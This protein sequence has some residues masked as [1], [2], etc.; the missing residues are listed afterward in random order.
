MKTGLRCRQ[1]IVVPLV[2]GAALFPALLW[3]AQSDHAALIK[4]GASLVDQGSYQSGIAVLETVLTR[5]PDNPE[6][7]NRL[8]K[9]YDSYSQELMEQGHFSLA[10]N[11]LKKM[12][13]EISR[14]A[15]IL[16]T[17]PQEVVDRV[18]KLLDQVKK[19]EKELQKAKT[20]GAGEGGGEQEEV[21]EIKGVKVL[22]F[23][24]GLDDP[25]LLRDLSDQKM[26]K[27]GSGIALLGAASGDKV[28]LILRVSKDLTK[29]HAGNLLKE[30]APIVGGTGGGRPDMA[31]GGG[32]KPKALPEALKKIYSIL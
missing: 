23:L 26:Q 32:S 8:L 31:Q 7:L 14:L 13:G 1:T 11:Y 9:A 10:T 15:Q 6:V 2:L 30:I 4:K 12:E 22:T 20:R 25:K 3:G 24:S 28:F 16:K 17:S 21:R 18:E 19:L 29:Y 27:L 5:D